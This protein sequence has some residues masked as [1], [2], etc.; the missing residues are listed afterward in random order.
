MPTDKQ[1]PLVGVGVPRQDLWVRDQ[2]WGVGGGGGGGEQALSTASSTPPPSLEP[3][4]LCIFE[5]G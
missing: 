1:G 5:A 2:G 4:A 3:S